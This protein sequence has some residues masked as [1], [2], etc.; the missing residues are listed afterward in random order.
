MGAQL[1][2][3]KEYPKMDGLLD[4]IISTDAMYDLGCNYH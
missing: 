3:R 1:F 4:A 2:G